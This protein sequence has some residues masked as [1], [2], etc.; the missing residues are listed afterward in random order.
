M[1]PQMYSF[2]LISRA[3]RLTEALMTEPMRILRI[4]V[5]MAT[6]EDWNSVSL[7]V[8]STFLGELM[9]TKFGVRK[10]SS[11]LRYSLS[12]MRSK[13]RSTD[14]SGKKSVGPSLALV[15][16]IVKAS[17]LSLT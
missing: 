17:T 12:W 4:L 7:S 8:I 16:T 2:S 13:S 6:T 11:P 1:I 5:R 14:W 3:I 15:S 10:G 9:M